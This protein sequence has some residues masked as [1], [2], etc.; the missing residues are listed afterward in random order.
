MAAHKLHA[1]DMSVP[2]LCPGRGISKQGRLWRYVRDDRPAGNEQPPAVL[3]RYSPDRKGERPIA[4]LA[5]FAGTLQADAHAGFDRLHGERIR[6]AGCWAR[7]GRKFDDIHVA[8]ESPIAAEALERIGQRY[9][10]ESEIGDPPPDER[11]LFRK[12][13]A[14]PELEAL[15]TRL[16]RT[17]TTLSKKSELA[18]AIRYA[19]SLATREAAGQFGQECPGP[20][21]AADEP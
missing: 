5:P 15:R 3:F 2:V 4:R 9:A 19:L 8:D 10:I 11:A 7:A 17:L 14:G 20:H 1:D 12:A 16:Q 18:V 6:E 13:R 21:R